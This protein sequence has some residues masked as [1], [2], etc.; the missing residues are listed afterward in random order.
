MTLVMGMRFWVNKNLSV[1][2]KITAMRNL[3][4]EFILNF[5]LPLLTKLNS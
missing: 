3:R 1:Y 4:C 2:L 5:S